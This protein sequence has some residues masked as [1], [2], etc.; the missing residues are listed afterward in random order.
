MSA[1]EVT[2]QDVAELLAGAERLVVEQATARAI[3]REL[4]VPVHA[5]VEA[6]AGACAHAHLDALREVEGAPEIVT[7]ALAGTLQ[8]YADAIAAAVRR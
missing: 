8:S 3:A 4:V 2:A 1:V 6:W 7:A 5:A